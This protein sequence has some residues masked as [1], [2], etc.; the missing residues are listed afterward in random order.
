MRYDHNLDWLL[1]VAATALGERSSLGA[2]IAVIERGGA[3][4]STDA[5]EWRGD[6]AAVSRA[7]DLS[8]VWRRLRVVDQRVLVA[9][10]VGSMREELRSSSGEVTGYSA[11]PR[12]VAAHLGERPG[13]A[14]LLAGTAGA[15]GELLT[16]CSDAKAPGS[17]A[18]IAR[19]ADRARIA[20]EDA[21]RA[22]QDAYRVSSPGARRVRERLADGR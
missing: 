9:H 18:V 22:W 2:Q 8:R 11:W 5:P 14:L 16:A 12:G 3:S 1:N 19:W 15:L 21:H 17:A 10:Y 13:V 7:R 20:T 4:R 6:L